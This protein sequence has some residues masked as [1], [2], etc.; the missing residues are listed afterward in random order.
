MLLQLNQG[1]LDSYKQE[2]DTDENTLQVKVRE[3]I[4]KR[5]SSLTSDFS[6]RLSLQQELLEMARKLERKA[7]K[8]N[9]VYNTVMSFNDN[10]IQ[11]QARWTMI[12]NKICMNET[13]T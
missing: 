12:G 11:V 6:D 1:I 4:E 7:D 13:P 9:A 5:N 2:L 3:Y 10:T 8:S